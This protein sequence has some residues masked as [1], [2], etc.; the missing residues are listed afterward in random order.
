MRNDAIKWKKFAQNAE[1]FNISKPHRNFVSHN[2]NKASKILPNF[3]Q[4]QS[5]PIKLNL[6]SHEF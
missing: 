4:P 5:H 3:L 2:S 6:M 1:I